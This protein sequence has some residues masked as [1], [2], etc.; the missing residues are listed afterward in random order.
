MQ[1]EN[2]ARSYHIF[3]GYSAHKR[4]SF[5]VKA[6]FTSIPQDFALECIKTFLQSNNSI[7]QKTKLNIQEICDMISLCFQA[8]FFKFDGNI[9]HQVIGTP[10]GSPA[11]VVIAEIVMQRIEQLIMP[12]IENQIIFWYRYVD[13]VI[14]CIDMEKITE[15]LQNIN[16]VNE[17]IQFTMEQEEN[18]TLNYLDLKLSRKNDG[19]LNFS[20][21]RKPTHTEKYLDFDSNH[22]LEHKNSVVQSLMHR[23][24]NL[25]DEELRQQEI[26]H[27]SNVLENNGYPK[28]MIKKIEQRTRRNFNRSN[29][30]NQV[31]QEPEVEK[32]SYISIPYIPG[33]SERLKRLFKRYNL[34][35]A[36]L[37]TRKLR[38]EI[39]HLKDKKTP[40]EKAGVV[41]RIDCENCD[42]RYVGETGRQVRDRMAEHEKDI[43]MKKPASK[44]SEHVQQTG[45]RFKFNEVSI[46]DNS[47]HR[48][49]R[50]H[51]ESIHT[52]KDTNAINRSL[53]LNSTYQPLFS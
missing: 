26:D 28:G 34:E 6:L 2:S 39:C 40:Q 9:F 13:D 19:S 29:S 37:P 38:S 12:L 49:T 5:D 31:G 51:L 14:T 25:C 27:V 1:L 24:F 18:L 46:L 48:K 16:S 35:V 43:Q 15:T 36:H 47:N 3:L 44:V 50:L 52:F 53:I 20:I 42:A 32:K 7:F 11:S 8:A 41:Y 22:P 33:T 45:H 23:A 17:S 21:F 30:N 10:M 4:I